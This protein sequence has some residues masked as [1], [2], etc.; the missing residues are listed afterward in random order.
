[1]LLQF[2]VDGSPPQQ[3][4]SF[5]CIRQPRSTFASYTKPWMS[6]HENIADI[7]LFARVLNSQ[8]VAQ[9]VHG[10][11]TVLTE[12]LRGQLLLQHRSLLASLKC[13]PV[14]PAH[15]GPFFHCAAD[16]RKQRELYC[17]TTHILH[18]ST[19]TT[20]LVP[21]IFCISIHQ[22][23]I[24]FHIETALLRFAKAVF[25]FI[26]KMRERKRHREKDSVHPMLKDIFMNFG[27]NKIGTHKNIVYKAPV[28]NHLQHQ[29]RRCLL[30]TASLPVTIT[31]A[32]NKVEQT[33]WKMLWSG[34]THPIKLPPSSLNGKLQAIRENKAN[35]HS[36]HDE[37][38]GDMIL[39]VI[40]FITLE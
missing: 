24:S 20:T 33:A 14:P 13:S 9:S 7:I 18:L 39:F 34:W 38:P 40:N 10:S 37:A 17:S 19:R 26:V 35:Q 2:E 25:G 23:N 11:L 30:P 21:L 16:K 31:H 22:I 12:N 29:L 28:Y 36:T 4:L 6:H 32:H 8:W 5:R 27:L 3:Y 15:A 1:M